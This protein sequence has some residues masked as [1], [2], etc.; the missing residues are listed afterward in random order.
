MRLTSGRTWAGAGQQ[1]RLP[2]AVALL[3]IAGSAA[4]VFALDWATGLPHVQHLYY[5]PII[6]AAT[7]FGLRGGG[8]AAALAIVLYHLAN[9]H[10]LSWRYEEFDVV[11]IAVFAAIGLVA[12]RLADDAR[13]LHQLAMTDDL[14]GL[15]NLRS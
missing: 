7:R 10:A 2:R 9:P 5:F 1:R 13:R 6:L 12:A 15:H 14:T 11:Q 8:A 4:V 3:A